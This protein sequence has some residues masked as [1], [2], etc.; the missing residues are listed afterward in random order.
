LQ[1][2]G[3]FVQSIVSGIAAE[4]RHRM[5]LDRALELA[6]VS[7]WEDLAN[8]GESCS[9]HVEYPD[10]S[11]VPLSSLKVWMIRNRGYG[12]LICDYSAAGPVLPAAADP[13]EIRFAN[14]FCSKT[15]ARDLDFVIRN[16]SRFSRPLVHSIHGLVQVGVPN[17]EDRKT[18]AAWGQTL[19]P[20]VSGQP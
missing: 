20:A 12:T 2:F 3:T 15:L 9:I 6:V 16:Q 1:I 8:P 13:T 19:Q 5:D 18:A 11:S 7:A 17:V 14:S 4:R 10:V